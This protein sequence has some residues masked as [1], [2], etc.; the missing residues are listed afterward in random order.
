MNDKPKKKPFACT[1]ADALETQQRYMPDCL[2]VVPDDD[3]MFCT[4]C[5]RSTIECHV[6]GG[7]RHIPDGAED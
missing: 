4:K 6:C 3:G 2:A 1:C 5:R 7:L